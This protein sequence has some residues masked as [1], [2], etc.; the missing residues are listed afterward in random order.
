MW[1]GGYISPGEQGYYRALEENW[2][3]T[4]DNINNIRNKMGSTMITLLWK[5]DHDLLPALYSV[6]GVHK[7]SLEEFIGKL[8]A[9][10]KRWNATLYEYIKVIR[11]W[12]N[13]NFYPMSA[14]KPLLHFICWQFLSEYQ[15]NRYNIIDILQILFTLDWFDING[16][17]NHGHHILDIFDSYES[18]LDEKNKKLIQLLLDYGA[19][20]EYSAIWHVTPDGYL[21]LK[22]ELEWAQIV[23]NEEI[24]EDFSQEN[25]AIW[26]GATKEFDHMNTI[27]A[28]ARGRIWTIIDDLVY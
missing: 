26:I 22:S 8:L 7:D 6:E 3:L 24:E 27:D 15:T 12:K 5:K 28:S 16:I 13:P 25:V 17:D 20:W 23:E 1:V 2:W 18:I 9:T 11:A 19:Q 10:F 4:V 21:I 14:W